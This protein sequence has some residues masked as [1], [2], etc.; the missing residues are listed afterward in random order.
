MH[1]GSA[2][3]DLV[4]RDDFNQFRQILLT[5]DSPQFS[6]CDARAICL[7]SNILCLV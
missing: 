6:R 4:S 1:I 5:L 2:L 7:S 3:L